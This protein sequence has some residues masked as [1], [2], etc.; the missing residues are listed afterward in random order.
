[1]FYLIAPSWEV[2]DNLIK[3]A[4]DRG[5]TISPH[6][7]SLHNSKAGIVFGRHN[8]KLTTSEMLSDRLVRLP[9]YFEMS[10]L[11]LDLIVDSIL[12]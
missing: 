8:F 11:E 5:I 2:R 3:K 1:M 4:K 9:I 10:E 12:N 6:Y 7:Q